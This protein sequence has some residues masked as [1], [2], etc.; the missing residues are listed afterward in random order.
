MRFSGDFKHS[1]LAAALCA[2]CVLP[3]RPTGRACLARACLALARAAQAPPPACRGL[4]AFFPSACRCSCGPIPLP[5]TLSG[6]IDICFPWAQWPDAGEKMVSHRELAPRA[7]VALLH[8]FVANP[9]LARQ[10]SARSHCKLRLGD[11]EPALQPCRRLAPCLPRLATAAGGV[12]SAGAVRAGVAGRPAEADCLG[13]HN[14]GRVCQHLPWHGQAEGRHEVILLCCSRGRQRTMSR[15]QLH[16]TENKGAWAPSRC[17]R[18]ADAPAALPSPSAPACT[19]PISS[20]GIWAS[21]S[22]WSS[23]SGGS[24]LPVGAAMGMAQ[25]CSAASVRP[26]SLACASIVAM[27]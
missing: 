13:R 4:P 3:V 9:V 17:P 5:C 8:R 6:K 10:F 11:W 24:A 26:P 18:G 15:F 27:A 21:A 2:C 19:C 1:D 12:C 23:R 20:A 14:Y 16:S 25:S 7:E 22:A